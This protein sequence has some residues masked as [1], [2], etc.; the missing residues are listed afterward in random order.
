M[1]CEPTPAEGDSFW[2]IWNPYGHAPTHK[3]ITVE[4]ARAEAERLARLNPGVTFY[5]LQAVATCAFNQCQW[6]A[7]ETDPIPF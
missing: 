2:M 3:H 6:K 1:Y 4:S 5:V 7:L